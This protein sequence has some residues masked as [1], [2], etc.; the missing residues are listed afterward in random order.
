MGRD[1]WS[2]S[3]QGQAIVDATLVK[4]MKITLEKEE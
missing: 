1:Y 3:H 2:L 4:D